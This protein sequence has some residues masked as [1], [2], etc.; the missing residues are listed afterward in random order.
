VSVRTKIMGIVLALTGV[1]GVSIT[2]QVRSMMS[3]TLITEL[4][5]RGHAVVSDLAARSVGPIL[6]HNPA[7]LQELLQETITNHPDIRYVIVV[8]P[9]GHVLAHTFPEDVPADLLALRVSPT[10]HDE[11]HIHYEN[12]EGTIHDFQVPLVIEGLGAVRLGVAETR[13]QNVL[14]TV[15]QRLLL[16]TLIVALIGILA[17]IFLTWLL[18]RPI[19]DLVETTNQVRHGNL[20]TR[21]L[22]W[23]DDEIGQLADAFNQMISA[24]QR[25]QETVAAKEEARTHLLSRL[26]EAQEDERK[27]IARDLHDDVG[28]ALTSTLVQIKLL[29]QACSGENT[30][31]ALTR[32]RA[33]V[34]QTL[35]TVRLLSRQLRP[36]VLDDLGLAI[37]LERYSNEFT[38]HYPTL[39]VDLHYDLTERLPGAVE[40]SLYRIIQEAMTNVARHSGATVLSVL[41]TLRERHVQAII[42]DNGRGFAVSETL[43]NK[44]SVG[45]HSMTERAE[46]L[47]GNIQIESNADGTTIFIEIPLENAS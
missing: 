28:Q 3:E 9:A 23:T 35:T 4:D 27:R 6:A 21:A 40:I 2:L 1:L 8:D 20:E 26:I 16:I 30:L 31:N 29:Q 17:A 7:A 18:T 5:N 14:D 12:Y 36:S 47:D 24:L 38:H 41:V 11:S 22:H 42:E 44:S 25:S 32:L 43:R 46:L 10:S 39:T 19:L 34:D 45:L 33:V 15:T 37:A 13:I